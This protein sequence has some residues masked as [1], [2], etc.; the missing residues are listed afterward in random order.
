MAA[1]SHQHTVLARDE[2]NFFMPRA[3]LFALLIVSFLDGS[4]PAQRAG[5]SFQGNAAG[6]PARPGFVGPRGFPNRSFPRRAIFSSRFHPRQDTVGSIV[7]PYF[8]PYDEPYGYEQPAEAVPNGTAPP[9]VVVQSDDR[10]SRTPEPPAKAQ[11]IEFPGAANSTAAKT[12]PP[13]IFI[14]ADGERLETRRFVLTASNLSVSIGRRQRTIPVDKLD[15]DATLTA[16]Q[17][18]GIDLRIPADR[19]EISL[20]F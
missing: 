3:A 1:G 16:N 17:E 11:V 20:S 4:L 19:N 5:A 14:L 10:Q 13:T 18:R 15:I 6:M 12:L 2:Y 9:V 7:V 8:F